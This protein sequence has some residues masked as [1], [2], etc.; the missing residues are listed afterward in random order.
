MTRKT[1]VIK[2]GGN[3]MTDASTQKLILNHITTLRQQGLQVIIIHGGGPFI[4]S[5]LHNAGIHS[6]FIDGQRVT[7][8]EAIKYVEMALK[9]EVNGTLVAKL[10]ALGQHAVGLSGKDGPLAI[11]EKRIHLDN[12]N[13]NVTKIDLGRVGDI[14]EVNTVLIDTLLSAGFLPVIACIAADATGKTFNINADV[15]AGHIAAAVGADEFIILTDVDGLLA[16]IDDPG[17]VISQIEVDDVS[18]LITDGIIKGG[19]VPKIEACLTAIKHGSKSAR[20]INGTKPEQL[21]AVLNKSDIGT[22]IC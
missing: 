15:F 9:G 2:Y 6:E 16:D 22:F 21:L 19:M 8:P 14:K 7:S 4:K 5:A 20:I 10:N 18:K 3:A 1:V 13:G 17:S 12:S 11:A